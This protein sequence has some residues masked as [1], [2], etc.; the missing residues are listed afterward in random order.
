MRVFVAGATGAIGGA[1]KS[2][3]D[4]LDP[5]PAKES[6]QSLAAIRYLENAVTAATDIEG[7]ALRYGTF[8]GDNTGMLDAGAVD[9]IRK[10][11]V[12]LI[13]SGAGWWSFTHI[14][15]AAEATAAAVDRG[16][17]I[18]NVVDDDPA[19]VRDWLPTLAALLGARRPIRFY[20]RGWRGSSPAS[21]LS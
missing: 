8:Y 1:V 19:Q 11:R 7:V 2:E 17:G 13:G 3:D 14:D 16:R 4:P 18:Y 21:I 10:R 5:H 12:P 9:Q 15:D 6:C 20:R